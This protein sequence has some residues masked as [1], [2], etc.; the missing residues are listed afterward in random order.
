[1]SKK[2]RGKLVLF[3]LYGKETERFLDYDQMVNAMVAIGSTSN[4]RKSHVLDRAESMKAYKLYKHGSSVEYLCGVFGVGQDAINGAIRR[5][6]AGR[7]GP[8]EG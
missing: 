2:P 6:E 7:Y 1:M 8:V 4:K 5:V 3:G